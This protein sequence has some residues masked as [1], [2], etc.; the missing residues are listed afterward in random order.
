MLHQ[1]LLLVYLDLTAS[2][3]SSA[4]AKASYL[5]GNF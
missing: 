1:R 4:T 3:E 5:A 2:G